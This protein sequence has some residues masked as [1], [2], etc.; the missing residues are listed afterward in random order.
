LSSKFSH[1]VTPTWAKPENAALLLP[2]ALLGAWSDR[3]EEDRKLVERFSGEKY[4]T[5]Q[6]LATQWINQADAPLRFVDRIYTFVSREDSWRLLSPL[7]TKDLLDAFD[8]IAVEVLSEDDPRYEMPAQERYLAGIQNRLPKFSPQVREGIAESIAL[9]GARGEQT[10]QGAP[11]GSSWRAAVQARNLLENASPERWFSLAYLLPL[12]A[13]AAP[14]EFLSA[15]EADL[16]KDSPSVGALFEKDADGLFSSSPHTGL[17]WALENLAWDA[18]QLSRVSLILADLVHL[19]TGGRIH[20]RPGGVLH[21]IF[22][23]WYPQTSAKID[24]RLEVLELL[25]KR[26]PDVAWTLLTALI[27]QGQDS[28]S[29]GSK[30]RWREYD[31]SQTKHITYGDIDKQVAWAAN[32]VVSLASADT[33]KWQALM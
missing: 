4:S 2:L 10:P 23:F 33:K 19:D 13:E 31:S 16:R 21:D 6:K 29:P 18:S 17:M 12:L 11:E 9:L 8:K 1:Q 5:I 15:I 24:E 32:R 22:R 25:A 7:F 28:A 20:P 14:D 30:P 26:R 3:G 27:S